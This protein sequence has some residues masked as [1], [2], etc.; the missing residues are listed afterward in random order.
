MDGSGVFTKGNENAHC[1]SPEKDVIRT[2]G[3]EDV[4]ERT[5]DG[6]EEKTF[7]LWGEGRLFWILRCGDPHPWRWWVGVRVEDELPWT[8]WEQAKWKAG[9]PS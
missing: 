5:L 6:G 3:N 8:E 1:Q 7:C 4:G 2:A 9:S